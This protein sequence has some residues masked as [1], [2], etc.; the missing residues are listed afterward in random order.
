MLEGK[1][2]YPVRQLFRLSQFRNQFKLLNALTDRDSHL[3][4]IDHACKLNSLYLA[5]FC[6]GK[7]VVVLAEQNTV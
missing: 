4:G 6:F 3:V 2:F 7:K 1:I 5:P